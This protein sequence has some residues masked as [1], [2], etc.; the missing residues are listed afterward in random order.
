VTLD[1]RALRRDVEHAFGL[2]IPTGPALV[3][4]EVEAIPVEVTTGRPAPLSRTLGAL[5]VL[6]WTTRYSAK[7]GV[8][9]LCRADGARLTFE[10]GGQV[11]YSSAPHASGTALLADVERALSAI[12]AAL[13]ADGC[14][15][16]FAGLDPRTPVGDVPLQLDAERYR[17]MDAYFATVGPAGRRM[18]RQTASIQL[19]VDAGPAPLDRWRLLASLAP[20]AAAMFA[21]SPLD[22]GAFTG[23][24]SRRRRI[25]AELDPLRT[26]LRA[27]GDDP[28]GE[29]L[30]FA[31]AAPAFLLGGDPG[32]AEPFVQWIARGATHDDWLAHLSTLFPDVRP[33]GYFEFRVA[34]AVA[35][36]ALPAL[37]ALVAGI[38][39]HAPSAAAAQRGLPMPTA[40]LMA[41]AGRDAL[42][43]Q[44]LARA[45]RFAS[46]LAIDAC[47]AL[48]GTALD[49]AAL[50]RAQRFFD[51][52]TQAGR[53]PA[54]DVRAPAAA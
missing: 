38:A 22:T 42:G 54:D 30:A 7:S 31:L 53:V 8:P 48:G 43:D 20:V 35:G 29:Y 24:S 47:R 44:S 15:L 18:M 45:S 41:R 3:G 28:V 25:W 52:Y 2:G 50:S 16:L 32:D 36:D 26:G 27:L 11:E 40:S 21:N 17:R 34:D 23:E 39:W 33:R 37:I 51:A 13:A 6:G 12:S 46:A 14:A 5:A 9:E 19:C 4:L 49:V 1:V 10:P